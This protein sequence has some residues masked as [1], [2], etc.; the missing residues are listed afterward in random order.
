MNTGAYIAIG[1]STLVAASL[2]TYYV[3]S[4]PTETPNLHNRGF[5]NSDTGEY[6]NPY[7]N[8]PNVHDYNANDYGTSK[9]GGKRK[10]KRKK[11]KRTFSK[12]H[13]H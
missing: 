2:F 6:N 1:A 9:E 8:A 11:S 7:P 13:K 4:K 10:S 12:K 3:L 5:F